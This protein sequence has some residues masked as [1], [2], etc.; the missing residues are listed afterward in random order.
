MNLSI[1]ETIT[2]SDW[3]QPI[4]PGLTQENLGIIT[5]RTYRL[6]FNSDISVGVLKVYQGNQLIFETGGMYSSE[7][8]TVSE[9]IYMNVY[10]PISLNDSITVSE[11]IS[12]TIV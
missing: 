6:T 9:I 5:G 11:N 1:Y 7:T 12:K 2:V 8:I 10:Y 4:L 3:S